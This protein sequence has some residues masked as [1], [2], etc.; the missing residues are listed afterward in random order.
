MYLL[1]LLALLEKGRRLP[2]CVCTCC[3]VQY[4]CLVFIFIWRKATR[5]TGVVKFFISRFDI[6]FLYLCVFFF[7]IVL[8][9]IC[10]NLAGCQKSFKTPLRPIWIV[11]FVV[12]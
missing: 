5:P 6:S 10:L 4:I 3:V 2:R 8:L 11:F 9:G 7:R 1:A 12:E